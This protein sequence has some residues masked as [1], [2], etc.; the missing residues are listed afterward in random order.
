MKTNMV[1]ITPVLLMGL[2]CCSQP[3]TVAT[4]AK[5]DQNKAVVDKFLAAVRTGDLKAASEFMADDFKSY[6]PSIK[7][8]SDRAEF[9]DIWTKRWET[10]L[11]S[12]SY[13]RYAN[14]AV[15]LDSVDWVDEWGM[16]DATYKNGLGNT[17]FRYHAA[18]R[19]SGDGKISMYA[20]FY[21]VADIME[22]QGFTFIPP[23]LKEGSSK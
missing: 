6:G 2:I 23:D 5:G 20:P 19:M 18:F 4:D 15:T 9:I 12:I 10:D 17:H 8:S 13:E 16:I 22:E 14:I 1:I 3:N 11:N 7:D 21:N